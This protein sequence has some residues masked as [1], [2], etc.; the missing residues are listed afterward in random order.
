[1]FKP[2]YKPSVNLITIL[3]QFEK[4][5][6]NISSSYTLEKYRPTREKT[7][8]HTSSVQ[9]VEL[10]DMRLRFGGVVILVVEPGSENI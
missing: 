4:G 10:V 3:R 1:M 2:Q 7:S 8:K 6:A 5:S 9:A